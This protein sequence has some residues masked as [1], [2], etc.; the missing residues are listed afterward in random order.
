[1]CVIKMKYQY[2]VG[3]IRSNNRHLKDYAISFYHD[4]PEFLSNIFSEESLKK[5]LN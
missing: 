3:T 2:D 4:A 1:M 5:R